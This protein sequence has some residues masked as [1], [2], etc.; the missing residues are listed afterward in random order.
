MQHDKVKLLERH[1][2]GAVLLTC[3]DFRFRDSCRRAAFSGAVLKAFDI[4]DF[5][6][7][8]LAG[9]A[10]NISSPDKPG[11]LETALDDLR[12]AV[13]KHHARRIVL[14]THQN[15][16]KYAADGYVF[17]DSETERVFHERELRL[18]GNIVFRHFPET[19]ILLGYARLDD[20]DTIHVERVKHSAAS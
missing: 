7:I 13:G 11:R 1:E 6:E 10:K 18:A 16:G 15:C 4:G 8:R 2:V 3:M 5:D 12:L 9:G 19:E 14:I 17:T 20:D